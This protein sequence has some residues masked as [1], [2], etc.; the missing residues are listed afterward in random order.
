MSLE[1]KGQRMTWNDTLM[2]VVGRD[3]KKRHHLIHS[4][5]LLSVLSLSRSFCSLILLKTPSLLPVRPLLFFKTQPLLPLS[6]LIYN[7]RDK[8]S[9]HAIDLLLQFLHLLHDCG[10][11]VAMRRKNHS[12]MKWAAWV[13][14]MMNFLVRDLLMRDFL[15]RLLCFTLKYLQ[16]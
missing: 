16:L 5:L 1:K 6:R 9:I 3:G 15:M 12:M 13:L 14:V 8:L 2:E 11:A 4:P 7:K 10:T